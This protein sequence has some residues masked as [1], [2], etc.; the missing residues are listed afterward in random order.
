MGNWVLTEY[1][2]I[3]AA[4]VAVDALDSAA[5]TIHVMGFKEG[6]IQKIVVVKS[7]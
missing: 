1:T 6:S 3:A 7:T 5:V 2:S 4:K